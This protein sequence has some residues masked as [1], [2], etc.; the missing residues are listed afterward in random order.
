MIADK[1]LMTQ[2]LEAV[3]ERGQWGGDV[4]CLFAFDRCSPTGCRTYWMLVRDPRGP[5]IDLIHDAA[6]RFP[7]HAMSIQGY[8]WAMDSN[9]WSP[10]VLPNPFLDFIEFCQNSERRMRLSGVSGDLAMHEVQAWLL[11]VHAYE[12]GRAAYWQAAC[13]EDA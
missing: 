13:P 9:A 11:K 10:W 1:G 4:S 6:G 12:A 5:D 7:H 3:F 2:L 8:M